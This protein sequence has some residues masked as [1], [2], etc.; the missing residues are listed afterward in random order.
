MKTLYY[1]FRWLWKQFKF[2]SIYIAILAAAL[3]TSGMIM[4]GIG[5]TIHTKINEKGDLEVW[6]DEYWEAL[7][8]KFLIAGIVLWIGF[9]IWNVVIKGIRESFNRFKQEQ[10]D[11]LRTIDKGR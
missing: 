8:D 3:F 2:D 10:R 7:G 5:L 11:L 9:V 1:Y 4:E 6:R